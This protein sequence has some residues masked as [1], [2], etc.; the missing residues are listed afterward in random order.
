MNRVFK[1]PL[2]VEQR[3]LVQMP[4]DAKILSV[5]SQN[6]SPVVWALLE[7]NNDGT[8]MHPTGARIIRGVTTGEEFIA[9]GC[10]FIGTV[11]LRDW[12][13][14]HVFEQTPGVQ[15]DVKSMRFRGEYSDVKVA[16]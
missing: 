2:E 1:Y 5:G 8:P 7:V 12:F 3:Q 10:E 16:L 4:I 13:V 9:A 11:T 14:F 6:E 15:G